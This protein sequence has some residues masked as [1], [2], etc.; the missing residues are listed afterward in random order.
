MSGFGRGLTGPLLLGAARGFDVAP[1]GL[2][3]AQGEVGSHNHAFPCVL[4]VRT[5]GMVV[6]VQDVFQGPRLWRLWNRRRR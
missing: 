1:D 3:V 4:V 2:E 6:A 5:E